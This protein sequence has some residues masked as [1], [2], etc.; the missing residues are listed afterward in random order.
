MRDEGKED[1]VTAK[2]QRYA[3]DNKL[4]IERREKLND[5]IKSPSSEK[6]PTP[7][8]KLADL[9]WEI[10]RDRMRANIVEMVREIERGL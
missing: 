4:I 6:Q 5:V 1:E 9:I 3:I 7:E 10:I 8:E 2:A